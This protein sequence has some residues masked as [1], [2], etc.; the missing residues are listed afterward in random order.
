MSAAL[1]AQALVVGAGPAGI[2]AVQRLIAAGR[3]TIWID[4]QARPG[5]QIWR[6][7]PERKAS[8]QAQAWA[9]SAARWQDSPLLTRLHSHAVLAAESPTALLLEDMRSGQPC[10]VAGEQLLLACGARERLLPFPGWTLPGVTGAGGLQALVKGGWPVA[11][12]RV[13][14]AGSGPLLLASA[15]TLRAA[16]AEVVLIAEQ[17]NKSS[18][19]RFATALPAGKLAQAASLRWRLRQSR[20]QAGLW[21][22]RALGEQRLEA[23]VL[24]DGHSESTITCDALGVGFGLL[25]NTELAELLGCRIEAG[26]I[27]VDAQQR[28]SLPGVFAAGECCGIGG[29][30]KALLEGEL[31]ARAMLGQ[32]LDDLRAQQRRQQR[33]A[34]ALAQHFALRPELLKLAE[35]KTLVCRCEDVSLGEL[36]AWPDWREAKL[37]TRCGMGACQGRICG[38]ITEQ[39]LVWPS[40]GLREPLQPAPLRCLLGSTE[41]GSA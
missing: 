11:G 8:A 7:G 2:A 16:G 19:A 21:P 9:A 36:K 20:Y 27:A 17:A 37:Q 38:P 5:G 30:D 14:L 24:S 34:R 10:R 26:A 15:D 41:Q 40:R 12:R 1:Q 23:V 33:F 4:N 28:T 31:A 39:L 35:A 18:L 25:P 29:V 22:V 32:P 3:R 6:G 13:V